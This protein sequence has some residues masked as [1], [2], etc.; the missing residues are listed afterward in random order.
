MFSFLSNN[1]RCQFIVVLH[2]G[3]YRCSS[4]EGREDFGR[5][6]SSPGIGVRLLDTDKH[7]RE[8]E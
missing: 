6:V 1:F 7:N 5:V 2:G 4:G 3:R 8:N